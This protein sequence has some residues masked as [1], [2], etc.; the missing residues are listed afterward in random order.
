MTY[1][2]LIAAK[3]STVTPSGFDVEN[4]H[5]KLFP[6]Q[7]TLVRWALRQGR[8]ALFEECGLGKT[9]QQLVWSDEI[10]KCT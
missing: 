1:D 10:V 3:L 8:A 2:E 4:L 7:A 6:W 9:F 5:P